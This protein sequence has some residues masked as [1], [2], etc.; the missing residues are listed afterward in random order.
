MAILLTL[1]IVTILA[2]W[3]FFGGTS[4]PKVKSEKSHHAVT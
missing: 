4:D 2:G 3:S 1:I